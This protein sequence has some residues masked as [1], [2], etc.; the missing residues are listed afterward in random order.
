MSKIQ[1]YSCY[2][3]NSSNIITARF[4]HKCKMVQPPLKLDHFTRLDIKITYDINLGKLEE[5]YLSLQQLLHPD[6]FIKKNK[7]E[8]NFA[9]KHSLLI[10]QAYEILKSPLKRSEYLLSLQNIQV[11]NN[12]QDAIKADADLL[13]D[14]FELQS[15]L[16]ELKNDA[17]KKNFYSNIEQEINNIYKKLSLYYQNNE[18]N[19]MANLT[20]KLNYL[21]KIKNQINNL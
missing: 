18:F 11:N 8:Q 4:C 17:D 9:L 12:H 19:I 13:D 2:N 3:C 21:E 15:E 7:I 6:L 16:G 10:N 1:S 14:I 20:I 5:N